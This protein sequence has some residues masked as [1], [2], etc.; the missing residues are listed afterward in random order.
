MIFSESDLEEIVR[1]ERMLSEDRT[2]RLASTSAAFALT[3]ILIGPLLPILFGAL[4]LVTEVILG[5]TLVRLA[6]APTG[7]DY[8][9][10]MITTFVS[11]AAFAGPPIFVWMDP[12]F[13]SSITAVLMLMAAQM[14]TVLVRAAHFRFGLM[15]FL[16]V[17]IAH[18]L[19]V[20]IYWMEGHPIWESFYASAGMMILNIYLLFSMR[21]NHRVQGDLARARATAEEASR[22]KSSFLAAAS[23]ELRTPLNGIVGAAELI[24]TEPDH[25]QTPHRVGI[26]R[27]SVRSLKLIVDDLLTLTRIEGGRMDIR[28]EPVRVADE[29]RMTIDLYRAEAETK[30][31]LMDVDIDPALP[32]GLLID[33]QRLRQCL[34]NLVSNAVKY[35]DAGRVMVSAHWSDGWLR[36]DVE[37]TGPG[38]PLA[39]R[40]RLFTPFTRLGDANLPGSGLG[41][42]IT[43]SLVS[44]MGGFVQVDSDP[45]IGSR[46]RIGMPAPVTTP[47][48]PPRQ[49]APSLSPAVSLTGRRILV[50]DD[51]VTNRIVAV[52][53]LQ[54][55]G[56]ETLEAGSGAEALER[57]AGEGADLVLL[58]MNMPG[59]DG[60]E[61]FAR[62]R[63]SGTPWA[64]VP[65]VAL[66]ADAM[67][68]DRE[69]Y[70]ALGIDGY[71]AKP[72]DRSR[73][74][75]ILGQTLQPSAA[76]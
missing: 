58:D 29:L 41:L 43:R 59:M 73:L 10:A 17:M 46:F 21:L 16:P 53:M 14:H 7:R 65:V 13:V 37:D 47:P 11:M 70:L 32:D 2:I 61:T 40:E 75:E 33:P 27:S 60:A 76:Q 38:I 44:A 6:A 49:P 69:R 35:T 39:D 9:L 55:E 31:L 12:T 42:A 22:I 56:F 66:T 67:D 5:R 24:D 54:Q 45:G 34:G 51:I 4:Y 20:L 57:L 74:R 36:I 68:E 72:L 8:R 1:A 18:A 71:I 28:P 25:P 15:A 63:A 50:V 30:R 19:M 62:I 26:L 52:A 23:H 48:A 64:D 3:V